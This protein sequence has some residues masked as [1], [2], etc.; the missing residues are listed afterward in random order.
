MSLFYHEM[1]TYV[2]EIQNLFLPPP[3]EVGRIPRDM[4]VKKVR[5]Q[6][7][8]KSGSFWL[9]KPVH[10]VGH[11]NLLPILTAHPFQ[12]SYDGVSWADTFIILT[13]Q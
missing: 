5:S 7:G 1:S 11:T 8:Q 4:I 3:S 9:V 6:F 13:I 2:Y 10:E 12:Q